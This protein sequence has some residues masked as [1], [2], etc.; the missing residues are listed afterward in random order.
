MRA[1]AGDAGRFLRHSSGGVGD[2][3]SPAVL[4]GG[5][6]TT[7]SLFTIGTKKPGRRKSSRVELLPGARFRISLEPGAVAWWGQRL[8]RRRSPGSL[9]IRMV[10]SFSLLSF[11][12]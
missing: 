12:P 4:G 7:R 11:Q 5:L 1:S 3:S 10:H 9:T 6:W 8:G 2:C